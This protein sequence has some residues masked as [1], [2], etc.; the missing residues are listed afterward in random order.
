M[1]MNS[2]MEIY[3]QCRSVPDYAKK[4]ISSGRMQGKTDISPMWR[5]EKLTEMFG[6]CGIGWWYEI[7]SQRIEEGANG[8]K[9]AFVDINLYYRWGGETS[10]AIPGI[11]GNT[12]IARESK[13]PY[14]D[15]E[16]FKKA[17][18]DAISVAAKALGVGADVYMGTEQTKYTAPVQEGGLRPIPQQ[19]RPVPQQTPKPAARPAPV[20][21]RTDENGDYRCADC[22]CVIE[23]WI[24][25]DGLQWSAQK[26]AAGTL[27][28]FGRQL[29]RDCG[30]Q[31]RD[32][33]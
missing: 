3:Q 28:Q 13:G 8:E 17:L 11:G 27:K 30:Q 4:P 23:P 6:P 9:K 14:T 15:D 21:P 26:L 10:R 20:Q 25:G 19:A 1:E 29:C 31:A 7:T 12:F 24:D 33:G 5:I 22:N 32:A 2:T 18:S 16:C